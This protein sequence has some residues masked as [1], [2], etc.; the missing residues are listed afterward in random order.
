MRY[1]TPHRSHIFQSREPRTLFIPALLLIALGIV[2]C[3][4]AVLTYRLIK[5]KRFESTLQ[6]IVS[7]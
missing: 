3:I 7:E 5:R 1:S 2:L 4:G 6:Q